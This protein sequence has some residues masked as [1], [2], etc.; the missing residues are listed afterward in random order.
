MLIVPDG[1]YRSLNDKPVADKLKEFVRGG[2]K[3]VALDNAVMQF[4]NGDWGLKAKEDKASDEKDKD[5]KEDYAAHI[6]QQSQ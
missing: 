5:K 4:A 3:I 1:N 6:N 2:G